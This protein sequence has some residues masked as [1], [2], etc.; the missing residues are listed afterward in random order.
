M[1]TTFSTRYEDARNKFLMHCDGFKIAVDSRLHPHVRGCD[2]E[3]LFIDV[4]VIGS[5]KAENTIFILSGTHGVEGY[6]GSGIQSHLLASSFFSSLPDE[7]NIVLVHGINPYGFSHMRRVNEQ[8]VDLNRNFISFGHSLP[9][10]TAYRQVHDFIAPKLWMNGGK[11]A[12]DLSLKNHIEKYGMRSLV[13]AV[14]GGQ[15]EFSDGL[16]YGGKKATWSRT[17]FESIMKDYSAYSSNIAVIDIHTGLGPYGHGELITLGGVKSRLKAERFYG[18]QV[19]RPED[20][21][22]SS[23]ILEGTLGA[24]VSRL[25]SNKDT[26]YVT[27]EFGTRDKLVVL[28]ALRADNWLHQH[29]NTDNPMTKPIRAQLM[30][31]FFPNEQIWNNAVCARAEEIVLK[32]IIGIKSL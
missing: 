10:N 17:T 7:V 6:C 5:R 16:F 26:T 21:D 15:Y 8:N 14:T 1:I 32:T 29:A 9:E 19:T 11:E 30:D 3:K 20:G 27:L 2:N 31:A 28:D 12:A 13:D 4:A 22:S 18:N 25:L 24:A 23:S